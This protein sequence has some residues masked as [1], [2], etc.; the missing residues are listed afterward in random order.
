MSHIWL[1]ILPTFWQ[2][3][4]SRNTCQ[5]GLGGGIGKRYFRSIVD[6]LS[7]INIIFNSN[8]KGFLGAILEFWI[9]FPLKKEYKNLN[10]RKVFI[11]FT[12]SSF[13]KIFI[14]S[15]QHLFSAKLYYKE[16]KGWK[17]RAPTKL[18]EACSLGDK[19][20]NQTHN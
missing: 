11:F 2:V 8:W 5:K 4:R 17:E 18:E 6:M 19:R 1:K 10:M 12:H 14:L 3:F 20:G 9:L 16:G 7:N 15:V 13:F